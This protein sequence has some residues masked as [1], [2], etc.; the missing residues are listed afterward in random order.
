MTVDHQLPPSDLENT[1]NS[2]TAEG[3]AS[4]PADA[5]LRADIR[6]LGRLLGESL[7]RQEGPEL[8]ELVETVRRLTRSDADRAAELL[9]D[10][11]VPTAIRLVRAFSEF[12][13]LANVTE[14][15]HRGRELA[16]KRRAEGGWLE[17][18]ARMIRERGVPSNE[19][20]AAARNLA[21]RPV[22]TAHPTEAARRSVLAK[23]RAIGDLLNAEIAT[24]TSRRTEQRLAELIDLLWQTDDLRLERP[25]PDDEARNAIYYLDDLYAEAAPEVLT[26]LADTLAELGGSLP[27]DARPL[28]FGTWTGGDRDGNPYVSAEVTMRVLRLQHEHG[29]RDAERM[30]ALLVDELSVSSRVAGASQELRDSVRADLEALP[31]VEARFRRINVE[32]PYRLKIRCIRAKLERTRQRLAAGLAHTPGL[33]YLGSAALL[34]DLEVMRRSLLEHR[35]SLV[36]QGRLTE[37]I[38]VIGAFGLHLATMDVREHADAHHAVL[39]TL[40]DRLGEMDGKYAELDRPQRTALLVSEL[41]SRRPLTGLATRLDGAD[42]KT[43]GVFTTIRDALNDFGPEVVESYIIS[44]TQGIDDVL[45]AVLLAREAGLVD[46]HGGTSRIGFVPLLE[47]AAELRAAGDILDKLLSIPAY[48]TIVT[49]R[50][51]VQE[52]MLGYSDSNKD[53]GIATSQW[54]IHK[55]QRALRDVAAKH[56]VRLQLFHG[57]GG[58]VGRGGGPTHDA[59]LAQPWG[60]LDG[61]IKVTEQGEVISDKYMLPT[62]ARENLELTVAAVLQASVLHTEPRQSGDQLARWNATM[63]A[64][65]DAAYG[66]YRELITDED[67][68]KYFWASTPAELLGELNIGSRPAKRPNADAGLSG[69][70]AI[71]W[72]F[73]WTQSRQIVPG[74]YGVG[75]GLAAARAAGLD[76]LLTEMH[77]EWHFFRTF[78]SNVEMT[79]TKT[80]LRIAAQ[81][82]ERLVPGELHH[83]FERIQREFE[84]TLSELLRLTGEES[85]LASQPQLGRTLAVRDRYLSPLHQL[86]LELMAR[87]RKAGEPDLALS[88]ALLLTVNGIAAGM[89]NTG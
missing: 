42:A 15:T 13:H 85:L 77:A 72:V 38:R 45:A 33:D 39:S 40:F 26:E 23:Q 46:V 74:W 66:R 51:E 31:E 58:T 81:Y 80:D 19:I 25:E 73:G 36:A 47:Q 82:V 10:A 37:A 35:G 63:E 30:L 4:E 6:R 7:V 83:V 61:A 65:S 53:A 79:L 22:F 76:G 8:L 18:T 50:G 88:R 20:A 1:E 49:A 57:R 17:A 56:G 5:E 75:S 2:E 87:R 41:S 78:I 62:L 60:T 24:G 64:I 9:R 11:D 70:R 27:A 59:I 69:L 89:R 32:E 16:A 48:R 14:Q 44:M 12:F 71:P 54:E 29:I 43:F 86:Q 84:L 55:A 21:V 3:V 28:T 68:P 34:E 52:V 67:L